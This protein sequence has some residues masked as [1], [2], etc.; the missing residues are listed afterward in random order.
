MTSGM[1]ENMHRTVAASL[2]GGSVI[3]MLGRSRMVMVMV[4]G[5]DL[6]GHMVMDHR[7]VPRRRRDE[8]EHGDERQHGSEQRGRGTTHRHRAQRRR[9]LGT[10]QGNQESKD[11]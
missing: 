10:G 7:A 6:H 5:G 2:L 3:V 9:T 1:S 11:A 8:A 4:D